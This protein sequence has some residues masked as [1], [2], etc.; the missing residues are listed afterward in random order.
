M[1]IMDISAPTN[2]IFFIR[3]I[4]YKILIFIWINEL[5]SLGL[6]FYGDEAIMSGYSSHF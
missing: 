1:V 5:V 2:I 6:F 3:I 4:I